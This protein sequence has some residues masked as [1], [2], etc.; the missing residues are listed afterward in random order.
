MYDGPVWTWLE[1]HKACLPSCPF[2]FQ[3]QCAVGDGG[4]V[5]VSF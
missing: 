2:W 5:G 1:V 3:K 4:L